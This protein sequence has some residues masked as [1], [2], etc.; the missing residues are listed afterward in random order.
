MTREQRTAIARII[1]D[2]INADY[3]TEKNLQQL[4]GNS[5]DLILRQCCSN[6]DTQFA[7]F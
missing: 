6:A 3:I 5:S 7:V 1:S 4:I 2:M